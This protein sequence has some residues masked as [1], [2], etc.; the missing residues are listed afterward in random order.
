VPSAFDDI[1]FEDLSEKSSST[2]AFTAKENLSVTQLEICKAIT[3]N[4][5]VF[6]F[7]DDKVMHDHMVYEANKSSPT[8]DQIKFP[9]IEKP[10][11]A[12]YIFEFI[13]F[14]RHRVEGNSV[15]SFSKVEDI[16]DYLGT[17]WSSLFQRLLYEQRNK[18]AERKRIDYFA[19]QIAD[20]K[21]VVMSS[22]QTP[23]L[24]QTANGALR[25]RR[26]IDFVRSLDIRDYHNV[27][28]SN[29]TWDEVLKAA[30][31]VDVKEIP[32]RGIVNSAINRSGVALIRSDGSF[33][34]VRFPFRI[35]QDLTM[36]WGSFTELNIESRSAIIDA[37]TESF[38]RGPMG[39]RL[40]KG[41]FEETYG[42]DLFDSAATKDDDDEGY[43]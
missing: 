32:G 40:A 35:Y 3:D 8:I 27:V 21:A 30:D 36:D 33:Y 2:S 18:E 4:I 11:T 42:N 28:I 7:V 14:L 20:L 6:T 34:E 39:A 37:V 43:A 17:Q 38:S 29:C 41:T 12:K 25:F 1:D 15:T 19:S 5:P 10:E 23:D 22:I 13:N 16:N 26:L 24:R 31:I 9:S